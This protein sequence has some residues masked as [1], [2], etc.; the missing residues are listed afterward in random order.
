MHQNVIFN[1]PCNACKEALK[2]VKRKYHR[3]LLSER[4]EMK[5][6]SPLSSASKTRLANALKI[7][8]MQKIKAQKQLKDIKSC[9]QN[10]S[11]KVSQDA[12]NKFKQMLD[13]CEMEEGS[14]VKKFWEEQQKAFQRRSGGMRWHPMMVRFAVLL[15]S[16]SPSSYRS[17]RELGVLKL[18]AEST[19]RDYTNVLHPQSGFQLEVFLDLK[20]ETESLIDNQRWVCLLFDELS[21][22]SGLVYDR[23]GGELVG[24]IE[25]YQRNARSAKEEHLASHALVFM[26]VGLTSNVKRSLGYF[27][28]RTATA[29]Q[30][31]PNLWTAVGLLESVCN[32][33]V[34]KTSSM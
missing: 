5:K 10:D 28:T 11:V 15:H 9:L 23:R 29:D 6:F 25:D 34:C 3:S 30:I 4:Q 17:L 13:S 14:F 19:L 12:H 32:L 18:P 33:K 26:V 21:I 8:R 7:T 24:F 31:F 20:K 16:Q 1:E 22:K 27:P 2:L